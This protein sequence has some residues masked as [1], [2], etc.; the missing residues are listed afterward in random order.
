M[1]RYTQI[2]YTQIVIASYLPPEGQKDPLHLHKGTEETLYITML[3]LSKSLG[4]KIDDYVF[5][6]KLPETIAP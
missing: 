2:F 4:I 3:P 5:L 6:E 1:E